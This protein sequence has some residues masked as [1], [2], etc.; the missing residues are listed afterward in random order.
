MKSVLSDEGAMAMAL[1]ASEWFKTAR[2]LSRLTQDIAL[3]RLKR[4][5][6]QLAYSQNQV[7]GLLA[8]VGMRMV[9]HDGMSYT[10]Q[11]PAEP[12]NPEDFATEDGLVIRE[13]LEPT[14]LHEGRVVVRGRVV[15][16]RGC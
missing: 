15:L 5:R 7:E 4:E 11:V 1:M 6:A 2:R 8:E 9:T 3:G 16:E 10:P 13:T 14:V 12:V